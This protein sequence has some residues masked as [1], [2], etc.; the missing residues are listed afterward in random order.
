MLVFLMNLPTLV[1]RGSLSILNIKPSILFLFISSFFR[2]SASIY[3]ER[4]LYM[5]NILPFLPTLGCL[6]ISGPGDSI[7]SGI[8]VIKII[9]RETIEPIREPKI[10]KTLFMKDSQNVIGSV[11]VSVAVGKPAIIVQETLLNLLFSICFSIEGML[12]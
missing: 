9:G 8:A 11:A 4:S 12:T 5:L 2:S 3:I 10:S 7:R 6:K 1:I